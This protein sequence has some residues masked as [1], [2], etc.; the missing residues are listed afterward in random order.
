MIENNRL[1]MLIMFYTKQGNIQHCILV[2]FF[3]VPN[4][5][6]N[7]VFHMMWYIYAIKN[8]LRTINFVINQHN[9]YEDF[10]I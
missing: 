6:F 10:Q 1:K 3:H 5:L 9:K 2:I 4:Y 8:A 7:L